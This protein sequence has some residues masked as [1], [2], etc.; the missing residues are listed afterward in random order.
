MQGMPPSRA[1]GMRHR[2]IEFPAHHKLE[3]RCKQS[4]GRWSKKVAK[5]RQQE[6]ACPPPQLRKEL[7]GRPCKRREGP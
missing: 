7:I 3:V 2:G 4:G 5:R 1:S 6:A